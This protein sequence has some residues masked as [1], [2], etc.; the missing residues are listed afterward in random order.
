ME[1]YKGFLID[2]SAILTSATAFDWYSQGTIF[3]TSRIDS[4]VEIKRIRGPVFNSKKAAEEHG[5]KLCK[6]WIDK[7]STAK[8]R[9]RLVTGGQLRYPHTRP[10]SSMRIQSRDEWNSLGG[11]ID[12]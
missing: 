9:I 10:T 1:R 4:V 8:D 2:G 7:R 6:D 11:W 5:L 3:G 12:T